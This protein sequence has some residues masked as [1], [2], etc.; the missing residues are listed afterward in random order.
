MKRRLPILLTVFST[1][2]LVVFF[3]P[4]IKRVPAPRS[5][6]ECV[7]RMDR[8]PSVGHRLHYANQAVMSLGVDAIWGRLAA[9]DGWSDSEA[10]LA[11]AAVARDERFRPGVEALAMREDDRPIT[12]LARQMIG[13]RPLTAP[14]T[15]KALDGGRQ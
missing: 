14:G 6:D 15:Q 8:M 12:A 5:V 11:L 1:L 9:S 10:V 4:A 3:M 7:E 2:L 13:K